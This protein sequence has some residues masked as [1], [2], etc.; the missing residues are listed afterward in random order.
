MELDD[1]VKV[2]D[3]VL[4]NQFKNGQRNNKMDTVFEWTKTIMVKNEAERNY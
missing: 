1:L 3:D 2:S 4:H